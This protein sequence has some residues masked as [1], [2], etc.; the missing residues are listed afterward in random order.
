MC[1]RRPGIVAF[2]ADEDGEWVRC[3]AAAA[4]GLHGD[5]VDPAEGVASV[6]PV[7]EGL[8]VARAEFR[9]W[10]EMDGACTDD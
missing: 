7:C 3:Y 5:A 6:R 4:E 8:S 10:K 1:V 2:G 9:C